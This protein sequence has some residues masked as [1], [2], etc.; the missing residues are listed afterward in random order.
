[1]DLTQPP[2]KPDSAAAPAGGSGSGSGGFGSLFLKKVS[3]TTAAASHKSD[4]IEE[5]KPI[6]VVTLIAGHERDHAVM[7]GCGRDA[8]FEYLTSIVMTGCGR[9]LYVSDYFARQIRRIEFADR[10]RVTLT[11]GSGKAFQTVEGSL[12]TC[13]FHAPRQVIIS[14]STHHAPDSVLYVLSGTDKICELDL[15]TDRMR[16]IPDV[17]VYPPAVSK[18]ALE[19]HSIDCTTRGILIAV[20]R[21]VSAIITIDPVSGQA[22]RIAGK[23][24]KTTGPAMLEYEWQLMEHVAL[25]DSDRMCYVMH[26]DGIDRLTL[27]EF[28]EFVLKPAPPAATGV[29]AGT[30]ASPKVTTH[31]PQ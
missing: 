16:I 14:R 19:L 25:A 8:R 17:W 21:S 11:A 12:L 26:R 30:A 5:P 13:A 9:Y 4:S 2:P 27:P 23:L 20:E 15:T 1:M 24:G 22:R 18:R 7:D 6:P 28:D 10:N 3:A 31:K 29:A